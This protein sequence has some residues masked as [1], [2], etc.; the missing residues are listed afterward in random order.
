[1]TYESQR[2]E[3]GNNI[4]DNWLR[5]HNE[6]SRQAIFEADMERFIKTQLGE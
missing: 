3:G 5:K 6:R 4:P 2:P 1:M